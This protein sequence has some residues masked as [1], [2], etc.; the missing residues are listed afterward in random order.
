MTI[1]KILLSFVLV[2]VIA[3]SMVACSGTKNICPAYSDVKTE[4]TVNP[5]S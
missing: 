2:A 3:L 5:N 1:K 4:T